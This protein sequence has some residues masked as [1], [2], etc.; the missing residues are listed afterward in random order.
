[1]GKFIVL[2]LSPESMMKAIETLSE[3]IVS[4]KHHPDVISIIPN[5]PAQI[6]ITVLRGVIEKENESARKEEKQSA[7]PSPEELRASEEATRNLMEAL[8]KAAGKQ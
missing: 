7:P 4:I 2:E 1:M 3:M 8:S 5:D 6:A